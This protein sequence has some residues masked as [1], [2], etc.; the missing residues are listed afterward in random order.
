M[1]KLDGGQDCE[2]C[3]GQGYGGFIFFRE[4]TDEEKYSRLRLSDLD[5]A[6]ILQDYPRATDATPLITFSPPSHGQKYSRIELFGRP[7][8]LLIEDTSRMR[9]KLLRLKSGQLVLH[10][11]SNDSFREII[12]KDLRAVDISPPGPEDVSAFS[13]VPSRYESLIFRH[14]H[15]DN[16][17]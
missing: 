13:M 12:A 1:S 15:D 4:K 7:T 11:L 2:C 16:G 8:D 17:K 9:Q 10:D 5:G 14:H 6:T 3:K